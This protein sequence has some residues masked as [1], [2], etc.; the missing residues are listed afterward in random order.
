MALARRLALFGLVSLLA[1][2]ATAK[3]T[4]AQDT[5]TDPPSAAA[6]T[7]HDSEV[8][9]EREARPNL[10]LGWPIAM[11]SVGTTGAIVTGWF[12]VFS[13]G[14]CFEDCDS[15]SVDPV[16]VSLGVTS[17]VFG[18]IAIAGLGMTIKR[19]IARGRI[20]EEKEANGGVHLAL[21]ADGLALR[22]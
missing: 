19:M 17:I 20:D 1:S 3:P 2:F 11:M 18:A 16:N 9:H 7:T 13:H 15:S 5:D 22:W 4:F 10:G 14:D 8:P 6:S 21:D 12:A